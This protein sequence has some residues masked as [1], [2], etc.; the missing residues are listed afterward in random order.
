[1]Y[2]KPN[3][4]SLNL[5]QNPFRDSLQGTSLSGAAEGFE[6]LSIDSNRLQYLV[7]NGDLDLSHHLFLNTKA[8]AGLL[9]KFEARRVKLIKTLERIRREDQRFQKEYGISGAWFL[10]PFL[11]WRAARQYQD[12]E[13]V[14]S[15]IFRLPADLLVGKSKNWTLHLEDQELM[16]N[17][18]LR[19]YIKMTW[20]IE[21]PERFEN[22]NV[23]E[24]ISFFEQILNKGGK[25][26]LRADNN[27][28]PKMPP[29][30]RPVYDEDNQITGREPV[31]LESELNADELEVYRNTTSEQFVLLDVFELSHFNASKM[32][33]VEDYDKIIED[34]SGHPIISELVLGVPVKN[35]S[36][37]PSLPRDLDTYQESQNHFVVEID[38]TQHRAV[39]SS[40]KSSAVVIQGPPGTGKSQTITNLIAENIAAG[41]KV[42]FVS[43]KRAA[44]DVVYSRLQRAGIADQAVLLHSSDLN[45]SELYQSFLSL[46]D[47][48]SDVAVENE[49]QDLC[50]DLD[51][52]KHDLRELSNVLTSVHGESGLTTSDI[53]SL[54]AEK[55]PVA[56]DGKTRVHIGAMDAKGLERLL[57]SLAELQPR[58]SKIPNFTK[59]PW[60]GKNREVIASSGLKRQMDDYH[61]KL[62]AACASLK[63]V[64]RQILELAPKASEEAISSIS[65]DVGLLRNVLSIEP[66]LQGCIP[67]ISDLLNRRSGWVAHLVELESELRETVTAPQAFNDSAGLADIQ[68]LWGYFKIER[69]VFEK[70][71][72]GKYRRARKLARSIC[73]DRSRCCDKEIYR[74]YLAYHSSFSSVAEILREIEYP[75]IPKLTRCEGIVASVS[76]FVHI[77]TLVEQVQLLRLQLR[78]EESASPWTIWRD[79]ENFIHDCRRLTEAV[80]NKRGLEKDIQILR[81]SVDGLFV[82]GRSWPSVMSDSDSMTAALSATMSD[83]DVLDGILAKIIELENAFATSKIEELVME[84]LAAGDVKNWAEHVSKQI[85]CSWFDDVRVQYPRLRQFEREEI[86]QKLCSFK[87]LEAEHRE[88]SQHVVRNR[89]ADSLRNPQDDSFGVRL[90]KKE[91]GKKRKV[92]APREVMEDGGLET[93]LSLKPVWLMSPLSIS[94]MLPLA[95]NIFDVIVF[96][97]AS[98][99]RVEDAIPSIYR[100]GRLVVVGDRQQM[101]PTNFFDGA[102]LA[103]DDDEEEQEEIPE[104]ILDLA[105]QVYPD[106]LLEW[107]YRSKNEALIAFSNR[108]FYGGR[109][110]APPNPQLLTQGKPIEFHQLQDAYFSTKEG[111][112]REAIAVVERVAELLRENPDRSVGVLALGQSQMKII[113]EVIEVRMADPSF[114][115][116]IEHAANLKEGE[117][118]VGFFVKNLE[119]I[120]GDERDVI[121]ISV[122]Y[123]PAR[124]GRK[125]YKNFG[126]LSKKG[127][128]RRLNVAVTRAKSKVVVFASFSPDELETD[129][130]AFAKNPDS[131]YFGR[132]LKFARGVSGGDFA[133]ANAILNSFPMAGFLSARKPTRFNLDV[134]RRLEALGYKVSTEIGACGYFIDLG[135]HH[136]VDE[137]KFVLGIEC[138]GAMFHSTPYARDRD[139]IREELLRS[140]GWNIARIWSI[141]WSGNWQAEIERIDRM[142]KDLIGGDVRVSL[143]D[144]RQESVLG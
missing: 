107:H 38:S 89:W 64:E 74:R 71:C 128:G 18:S 115:E 84:V 2:Y 53:L 124:A 68:E 139:K 50:K 88:L 13:I 34:A 23:G 117:A 83:L 105:L 36:A 63:S 141:D 16:V 48:S 32:A 131:V 62:S 33:L 92:K 97:E 3:A 82:D 19:L 144:A 28:L 112:R 134:K 41:K 73:K 39:E 12:A 101:P 80:V 27:E 58:I 121:L 99:V 77:A 113:D 123:A 43:E 56:I 49:W 55:G 114:R 45:K 4:L 87:Q 118:D 98:Q 72:S 35:D 109:L 90:L 140:R 108:A 122:G 66:S 142:M 20:G 57:T 25:Q 5:T 106:V 127:G 81:D 111:N 46:I 15:P 21:L 96:D 86:E 100:A 125:L 10:G 116:L 94:Q 60:Q 95:P 14:I 37:R 1:L 7:E 75:L 67:K 129:E 17:P 29:K 42:L 119:N 44:L 22:G 31:K 104:S 133:T 65:I 61:A 6:E 70:L 91:V 24:A 78:G 26:L 120:Q 76:K 93:M 126:P 132:Y 47:A 110:I 9:E 52:V 40:S 51:W 135:V 8:P 11:C 54:Y 85:I 102:G 143:Q 69:G 138:D 137:R 30:Y 59:H 103:D 130:A 79:L 136:P